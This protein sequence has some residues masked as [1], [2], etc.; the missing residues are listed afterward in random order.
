MNEQQ[1]FGKAESKY[2]F[3]PMRALLSYPA[4]L[5]FYG[6]VAFLVCQFVLGAIRAHGIGYVANENGPVEK[7]Q[8]WLA[9]FASGCL[10]FAAAQLRVGRTYMTICAC[11]VGYAAAREC[12]V[13]FETI[14][15]DDAY[16][17]LA[18]IPLSLI[19]LSALYRGR[20]QIFHETLVMARTPSITIFAFAGIYICSVCQL[21]DR[22]DLWAAVGTSDEAIMTK[23]AVEEFSELFGYLL[24]AFSGVE[25]V[26][27]A[28]AVCES[29]VTVSEPTTL[30]TTTLATPGLYTK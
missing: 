2:A 4:R 15:F 16:K 11:M 21:I 13:W 12:D 8:V 3:D 30:A 1:S 25:S 20:K 19:A 9:L 10:F 28:L 7:A 23:A 29:K 17:Y 22:P 6:V 14:L 5:T 18:G 24:L 26:A 27:M